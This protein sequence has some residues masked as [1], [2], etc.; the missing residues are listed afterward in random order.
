MK[1]IITLI[2]LLLSYPAFAS[3]NCLSNTKSLCQD[4][5]DKEWHPVACDCPCDIIKNSRC[6]N[7]CGHLQNAATYAV[8]L[9][10]KIAHNNPNK[11]NEN[12]MLTL[13]NPQDV[14]RKLARKYLEDKMDL[15]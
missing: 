13:K 2:I 6:V 8:V 7:Q 5:D 10:S 1:K 11:N 12:G 4:Y 9:P 14:L 3:V 15:N